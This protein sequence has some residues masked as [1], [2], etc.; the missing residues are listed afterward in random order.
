MMQSRL[1]YDTILAIQEYKQKGSLKSSQFFSGI[2]GSLTFSACG[3]RASGSYVFAA[4]LKKS[5]AHNA[6]YEVPVINGWFTFLEYHV[7][8]NERQNAFM[9]EFDSLSAEALMEVNLQGTTKGIVLH[10]SAHQ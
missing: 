5:A 2:T 3:E 7:Q 8:S 10:Q 1:A 9:E 6:L 4:K